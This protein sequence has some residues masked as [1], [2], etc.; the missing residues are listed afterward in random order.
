MKK[1]KVLF[2][3]IIIIMLIIILDFINAKY[4]NTRP[5]ISIRL[6]KKE[7][8]M[9]IYNAFLYR[10]IECTAEEE[11]YVIVNYFYNIKDN[12]C[13]KK[14]NI[15]IYDGYYIN[16]KNVKIENQIFEQLKEFYSIDEINK[17]TEDD[18]IDSLE[19]ISKLA[20][21]SNN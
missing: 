14:N 2:L 16:D 18:V 1:Y 3:S 11:H 10:T 8:Q 9:I 20:P 12:F 4:N 19:H 15:Q 5:M 17:M 7:Q 21:V 13:P 6:E